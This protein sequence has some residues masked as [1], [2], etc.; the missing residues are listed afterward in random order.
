MDT[1]RVRIRTWTT[2]WV[3]AAWH[4]L[5]EGLI[6]E[7]HIAISPVLLGGGEPLFA[8][9]DLKKLGYQCRTHAASPKA[10]HVVIAKCC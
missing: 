8:G 10:T 6:D 1:P 7:M 9:I 3:W 2:R 5:R 4:C